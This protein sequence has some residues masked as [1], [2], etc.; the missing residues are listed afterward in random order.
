MK[1]IWRPRASVTILCYFWCLDHVHIP[2]KDTTYIQMI[3]VSI[4][5]L[6]LQLLIENMVVLR[7]A[8]NTIL[9]DIGGGSDLSKSGF[10]P[11]LL[12]QLLFARLLRRLRLGGEEQPGFFL[13]CA[14][15]L[16]APPKVALD[17]IRGI[18]ELQYILQIIIEKPS[19]PHPHP[20]SW[21]GPGT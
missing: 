2:Q 21:L 16:G 11:R 1:Q 8:T 15:W 20:H 13:I 5:V 6:Y 14:A 7:W 10:L 19:G 12:R 9:V 3:S 17:C 18:P 4:H